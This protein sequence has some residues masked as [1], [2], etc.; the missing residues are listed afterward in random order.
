MASESTITMNM[1]M[2][3]IHEVQFTSLG[4]KN[5]KNKFENIE[6]NKMGCI[7]RF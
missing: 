2:S 5:L 1:S 4:V 3:M 6:F 7:S